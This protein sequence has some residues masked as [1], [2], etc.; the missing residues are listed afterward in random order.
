MTVSYESNTHNNLMCNNKVSWIKQ[1]R[2]VGQTRPGC[3]QSNPLG[4]QRWLFILDIDCVTVFCSAAT[5]FVSV[6]ANFVT[7]NKPKCFKHSSYSQQEEKEQ[8]SHRR[9]LVAFLFFVWDICFVSGILKGSFCY[10]SHTLQRKT[11]SFTR[12]TYYRPY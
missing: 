12:V 7:S 10:T 1:Q 2:F 6:Y 3:E 5:S 8:Q 11:G 4:R 9:Y